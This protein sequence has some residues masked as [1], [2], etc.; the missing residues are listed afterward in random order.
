MSDE[1]THALEWAIGTV[2][3]DGDTLMA[4]YCVDE[5]Q[6]IGDANQVPD[7][8][9]A[10]KEQAAAIN[11]VANS[12]TPAPAMTAVPEFV[13]ASIRDSKNNTP[14]TSPAPSSRGE[15][16]RAEGRTAPSSQGYLGQGHQTATK[17][18]PSGAGHCGGAALQEPKASDY[19]G[20]RPCQPD[21]GR[22]R[23]PRKKCAEGC[24][25]G[26]IFQ[27]PS[28]QELGSCHGGEEAAP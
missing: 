4:I 17:D 23:K 6:G 28:D 16:S 3:R 18:E 19:R 11:T 9:K 22:D 27:L 1:S 5:E 26:I 10:M 25:S 24:H 13:R 12:K 2:L 8:P 15:R 7:D 14:N 20:D 21:T